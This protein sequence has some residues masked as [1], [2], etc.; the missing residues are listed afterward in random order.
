MVKCLASEPG[1]STVLS[2]G[3]FSSSSSLCRPVMSD[4]EDESYVFIGTAL[5]EEVETRAG[6]HHKALQDP[7]LTKSLPVWKQVKIPL[8]SV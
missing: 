4:S 5:Q 3:D 2:P 7:S 6:Q 8:F 1:H